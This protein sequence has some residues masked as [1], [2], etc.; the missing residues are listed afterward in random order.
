MQYPD[1]CRYESDSGSRTKTIPATTFLVTLY[2]YFKCLLIFVFRSED[3]GLVCPQALDMLRPR[4]RSIIG[5]LMR[6]IDISPLDAAHFAGAH[7]GR[8]QD[9]E[10]NEGTAPP[11]PDAPPLLRR[12]CRS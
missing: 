1:W 5:V 12:S 4:S 9:A 6:G 3:K 7:S 11:M 2:E 8:G 10:K